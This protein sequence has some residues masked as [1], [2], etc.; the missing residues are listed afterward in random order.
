MSV[1]QAPRPRDIR[2]LQ[3]VLS[4]NP[5]GTERLV[6]EL[7]KRL[8]THIPMAV[9]CLDEAGTWGHA[10]IE[11]GVTVTAAHRR[12]G[13]SPLLG[14]AVA[15]A[16]QAHRATVIHAHQYTPFIYSVLSRWWQ[17]DAGVVFTEHGRLSDA[18]ASR[19]R[20]LA[21]WSFGRMPAATFAVSEDLRA[22][23]VAEGFRAQAVKVIHNG[24]DVGALPSV[25]DRH[26]VRTELGVGPDEWLIGTVARLDPVKSLDT[27]LE[28][29]PEMLRRRPVRIVI[30]GDGPE[31]KR[32]EALTER[33]GLRPRVCFLGERL[34]ARRWLAGC[35]VYV[36]CSTSEG[37]SLTILEAMAAGLPVVATAVGGTPEVVNRECGTLVPA[38]QTSA[39]AAAI[40]VLAES[41]DKAHAMGR[42]ARARV[43]TTFTIESMVERYAE[44]YRAVSGVGIRER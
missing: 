16:V 31:R 17:R 27:L 37:I 28:A 18:P 12:Q 39:L 1:A 42:A 10:L 35:D 20:R 21:N 5:G 24:I 3:V 30:V 6:V 26:A 22:F 14:R 19:K 8:N 34:D 32:L 29:A 9:C 13:F 33:L 11:T 23:M 36:N 15:A 4:L 38:G 40:L 44:V 41:P 25:N 7:V 2:V 43:E